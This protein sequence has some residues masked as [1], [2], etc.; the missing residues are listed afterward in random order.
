MDIPVDIIIFI[1]II[2][3]VLII[4]FTIKNNS[5]NNNK[6]HGGEVKDMF[7]QDPWYTL[8]IKGEKT[9]EGRPASFNR[10][11]KYIGKYIKIIGPNNRESTVRIIDVRHYLD[12]KEYVTTEGWKRIAP[13]TGS[14]ENAIDAYR[15]I[16]MKDYNSGKMIQVFSDERIKH[17]GGICAIALK[18]KK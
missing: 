12:L 9:V 13:H 18:V 4:C 1:V 5:I 2:I 10:Y 11:E 8:I 14:N 3:L 17:K 7:I 6:M 16:M 15:K